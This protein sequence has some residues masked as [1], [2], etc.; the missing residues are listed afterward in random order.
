MSRRPEFARKVSR[1]ST[2]GRHRL[3]RV[4]EIGQLLR[5]MQL[6]RDLVDT[7]MKKE[8]QSESS[9]PQGY[10]DI[11][12]VLL[13]WS[14]SNA[15]SLF[16]TYKRAKAVSYTMLQQ[17]KLPYY[18]LSAL[19]GVLTKYFPSFS[20]D[21]IINHIVSSKLITAFTVS[22][23]RLPQKI[24]I[25]EERIKSMLAQEQT[26]TR[27]D[28][29][30]L[31]YSILDLIDLVKWCTSHAITL[32]PFALERNTQE[33]RLAK[34]G[35][36]D[37]N[38]K[39]LCYA[40]YN[41]YFAGLTT[42][43]LGSNSIGDD[44][45]FDLSTVI[46]SGNLE[47][48]STLDINSNKFGLLGSSRL[49]ETLGHTKLQEFDLGSNSIGDDD[50]LALSTV[51]NSGKLK[52]LRTLKLNNNNFGLLRLSQLFETLKQT[53]LRTFDLSYN[54]LGDYGT[55]P[56]G[57]LQRWP[58]QNAISVGKLRYLR[59]LILNDNGI[60]DSDMIQIAVAI[61]DLTGLVQLHLANNRIGDKGM[62]HFCVALRDS[63]GMNKLK[64]LHLENNNIGDVGMKFL[65]GTLDNIQ[66]LQFLH[67]DG[68][69]ITG[70]GLDHIVTQLTRGDLHKLQHLYI[71]ETNITAADRLV[72]S[73]KL[74]ARSNII[75]M[76]IQDIDSDE[77]EEE[78]E[79][80]DEDN[81]GD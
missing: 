20:G 32:P 21:D 5:E 77:E 62:T 11:L 30:Y 4:M 69:P 39:V 25:T 10:N 72:A 80:D 24:D 28:N 57:G 38:I 71:Q 58:I 17:L 14:S 61:T 52:N 59:Q 81:A 54:R 49:F 9:G 50:M 74:G 70:H 75:D 37:Q 7:E 44:G 18:S 35:I 2:P 33:I 64:M 12:A 42:L 36:D 15:F 68:N 43:N 55:V 53:K 47:S 67:L 8:R 56:R 13:D 51:I 19:I 63:N 60:S 79:D 6:S 3:D 40:I 29:R 27:A 31:H 46:A 73:N 78:E 23:D 1:V 48:L 65:S 34:K 76:S 66:E 41:Q 16:T 22:A 26:N 45:M